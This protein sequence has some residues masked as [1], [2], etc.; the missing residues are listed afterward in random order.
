MTELG[1]SSGGSGTL[2]LS[3]AGTT[4]VTGGG[5]VI[6]GG[7][8]SG[9]LILQSG[10]SVD[11]TADALK[12]GEAQK[13]KGALEL[14][15]AGTSLTADNAI[16]G[17][18]GSGT[19][20]VVGGAATIS[21]TAT[22]GE[23]KGGV[24]GLSV[25]DGGVTIAGDMVVGEAGKGTLTV[26]PDG[27]I[28][29]GALKIPAG[30]TNTITLGQEVGAKGTVNVSGTGA[31]L[32]SFGL[33]VGAAGGGSLSIGAEGKV[34]TTG[35]AAVGEAVTATIQKVSVTSAGSWTV[36]GNLSLGEAAIATATISAGGLVVVDGNLAMGV[37][38]D[39]TGIVVLTGGQK[40]GSSMP[41]SRLKWGALLDVGEAGTGNVSIAGGAQATSLA[42]KQGVLEIGSAK[43]AA[44]T[45]T[46]T[47]AGSELIGLKLAVGG[48]L[49]A[50]G[51]TGTL[52]VGS[53]AAAR[54]GQGGVIWAWVVRSMS[55]AC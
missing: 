13:S 31:L 50:A 53:G 6:I 19:L 8:G 41:P 25:T 5:G 55:A 35:N 37:D 11:T 1:V 23:S 9:T 18:E 36:G 20:V 45:V 12:L 10:A 7:E 33:V 28:A 49:A 47:D 34:V 26:G 48:D 46:V 15:D 39:A 51:G 30:S 16:I 14:N 2:T 38:A 22:L 32:E 40:V 17:G 43:G 54:F 3:D 44:G 4:L 21:G 24:G 52:S 29:P 42:G 27:I